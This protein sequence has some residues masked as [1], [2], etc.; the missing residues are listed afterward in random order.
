MTR[1]QDLQVQLPRTLQQEHPLR[2]KVCAP[3]CWVLV[4]VLLLAIDLH[5]KQ[6]CT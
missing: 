1:A 2:S 5:L 3:V 6:A 4:G